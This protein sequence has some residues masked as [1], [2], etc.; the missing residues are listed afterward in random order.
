MAFVSSSLKNNIKSY[1]EA[2]DIAFEVTTT[3]TQVNAAI[4]TNIDNLSDAII[5]AFL[6]SQSNSSQL[7][8]EDLELIHPDD[9]EEMDL[10]WQMAMLT[11][12]ARKFLNNI[13]RKL[14][15]NGNETVTFDKT[16]VECYNYHKRGTLQENVEHQEHMT[17]RT[18]RAQEGMC[19]LKLLTPQLWCLVMVLEVMIGV[20]KLKND[21]TMH[22]WH[23]PL[24]V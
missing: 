22:L 3:G 16:K 24:Q 7:V 4:S 14:N 19:L 21:L 1:N 6:A 2:V 23:T 11:M 17:I 9:L 8:N 10:K 13:R 5:F 15:L 20:T 18:V 12:R